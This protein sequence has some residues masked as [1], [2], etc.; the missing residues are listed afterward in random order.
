M[1]PRGKQSG[2]DQPWRV[3][4]YGLVT[5]P[6]QVWLRLHTNLHYGWV[7]VSL[8]LC[9]EQLILTSSSAPLLPY[10]MNHIV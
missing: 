1:Q 2:L 4:C 10:K 5:Y 7:L 9:A 8:K 6:T 3:V